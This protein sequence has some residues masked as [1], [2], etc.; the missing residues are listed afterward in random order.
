MIPKQGLGRF[1][2]HEEMRMQ[3]AMSRLVCK[4]RPD[5]PFGG[6]AAFILEVPGH[7]DFLH[8]ARSEFG[9]T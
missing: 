2:Q 5:A 9:H 3:K 4:A 1:A 6:H 7:N 8:A